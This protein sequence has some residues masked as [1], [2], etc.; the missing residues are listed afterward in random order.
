VKERSLTAAERIDWLRLART[1]RVGPVTFRELIVRYR[2]PAKAIAALPRLALRGG[3]SLGKI[4][5]ADAARA[6]IDATEAA[7]GL[8][9]MG[10]EPRFP[11]LLRALDPPPPLVSVLGDVSILSKPC[12]AIVG[13]RN[14]SAI[15]RRFAQDM[16]RDLGAAGYVVVSGLARG[17]DAAA[18]QGALASGTVAVVAGGLAH[19]YPPEHTELHAEIAS[20]GAIVS[21]NPLTYPPTARDFPRRN[22]LISGLSL[23]VVVIEAAERSGSLITARYA[24]EQGR[25]VMAAPGSPLDPRTKGSNRLIREG[26]IL[27]ESA[28]DVVDALGGSSLL[29]LREPEPDPRDD[30]PPTDDAT[31]DA[32]ADRVRSKVYELL[33]PTPAPTD[34]IIRQA[35]AP[36]AVA[37]AALMELEL[38]GR[39]VLLPGGMAARAG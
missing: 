12:V 9:V 38:A 29:R 28:A 30:E 13:S 17:I 26:A 33:S 34:E 35:G 23:G 39:A 11:P 37:L 8:V 21:E 25:E 4:P 31:L 22:R 1:P 10:C 32:E 24:A 15:G 7:R 27:I 20:K 2:T 16:A 36:A 19:I 3:A 14:A 18:H 5:S 6:E